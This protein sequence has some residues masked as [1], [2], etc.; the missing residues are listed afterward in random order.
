MTAMSRPNQAV[1][2]VPAGRGT[3]APLGATATCGGVNFSLFS[4]HAT[5]VELL[6]FPDANA[7]EPSRIVRLDA[8]G[9]RSYHYWHAFVPD[10]RP[11]QVYGY[12]VHGPYAP[13]RGQRFDATKL[14]LDPYGRAVA[15]PQTYDRHA[16]ARPGDNIAVAMRS[17]VADPNG[18][19]W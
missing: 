2:S 19:Y 9:H 13:E 8:A 5:L 16:A 15:V 3:C 10:L 7:P 11:G 12:R 1:R 6:L 17:V 4:K 14:L 18:Y